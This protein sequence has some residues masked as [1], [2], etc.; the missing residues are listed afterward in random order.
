M[1]TPEL[2]TYRVEME[3]RGTRKVHSTGLPLHV[4]SNVARYLTQSMLVLFDET[5]DIHHC[6]EPT[7][8]A[9]AQGTDGLVVSIHRETKGSK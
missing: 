4:A 3:M 2:N 8:V 6:D 9:M 5:W 7:C 1:L